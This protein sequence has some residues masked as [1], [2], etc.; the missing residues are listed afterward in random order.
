MKLLSAFTANCI[1]DPSRI[2]CSDLHGDYSIGF[3]DQASAKVYRY[4]RDQGIG[5]EQVVAIS[6]PRSVMVP[7]AILGVIKAGAAFVVF[8]EKL[9]DEMRDFFMKDT[10][11]VL[12]IDLPLYEEIMGLEPLP[13][14][15]EA[16]PHDLACIVYS[17]GS[18]GFFRG[19]MHEYGKFEI[20]CRR[21]ELFGDYESE[22]GGLSHERF[23]MVFGFYGIDGLLLL[24]SCLYTNAYFDIIP[25]GVA[26]DPA[27]MHRELVDRRLTT[28]TLAPVHLK[29]PSFLEGTC[30]EYVYVGY[31]VFDHIYS[32]DLPIYNA[33][34]LTEAGIDVMAFQIDR[35]Y[36]I[37]P[38]GIPYADLTVCLK[39][40][41]GCEV[42]LGEVGEICILSE[43][44]RGYCNR[45]EDTRAALV[46]GWLHTGDMARIRPDGNYVIVG[47]K[48]DLLHT[49]QGW[50]VPSEIAAAA[51][52]ACGLSWAYVKLY[53]SVNADEAASR[54]AAFSGNGSNTQPIICLYYTDDIEL[55]AETIR[56]RLK[57][58]LPDYQQPTHAMH[59]DK[60]EYFTSGKL[61]RR[62]FPKPSQKGQVIL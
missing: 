22:Y 6:L 39:D 52:C 32:I 45:P 21:T 19:S 29:D 12:R 60:L 16:D 58:I 18:T 1:Q 4:L 47:R 36:D 7:A 56:L 25:Y 26:M 28:T 11:A 40:E 35:P 44:F 43:Y 30:L 31:E 53:P 55:S 27:R 48:N 8:G 34:G 57:G 59:I 15:V 20:M 14:Y 24:I 54:D 46:D 49:Q 38:A 37:T 61:N 41:T 9:S 2:L 13:G 62:A 50:I 23:G 51:K 5:R 17:S 10:G 3:L 33:Y 42:P